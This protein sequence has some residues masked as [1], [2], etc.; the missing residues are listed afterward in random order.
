MQPLFAFGLVRDGESEVAAARLAR[1]DQM[2][3][4]ELVAMRRNPAHSRCTVVQS[5]WK[6]ARTKLSPG[7]AEFNPSDDQAGARQVL[8]DSG[9]HRVGGAGDRH[10]ATV[11]M[12]HRRQRALDI[13]AADEQRDVDGHAARL[14]RRGPLPG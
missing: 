4:A 2:A 12:H 13:R 10:P 3:D 7:I 9:V 14:R 11:Q 1:H 8:P 6:P 5:S